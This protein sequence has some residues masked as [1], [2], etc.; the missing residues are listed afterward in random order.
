YLAFAFSAPSMP[1]TYTLAC[2]IRVVSG[3]VTVAVQEPQKRAWFNGSMAHLF[4][5]PMDCILHENSH[6]YKWVV[7]N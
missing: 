3:S 1:A 2:Q 7:I 4:V 5:F 6:R